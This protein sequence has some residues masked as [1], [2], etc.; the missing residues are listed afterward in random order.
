MVFPRRDEIFAPA[1]CE[2]VSVPPDNLTSPPGQNDQSPLVKMTSK[3]KIV[4]EDEDK[5]PPIS[6]Q[7]KGRLKE[8][9]PLVEQHWNG[10]AGEV[11]MLMEEWRQYR[12]EANHKAYTLTGWKRQ[13]GKWAREGWDAERIRAAIDHSITQG[14]QGIYEDR[15]SKSSQKTVQSVAEEAERHLREL[16]GKGRE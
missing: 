1:V 6:P 12:V 3:E 4:R 13:I 7:G 10:E 5:N 15:N 9:L 11:A 14:F 8:L 2:D 16:E